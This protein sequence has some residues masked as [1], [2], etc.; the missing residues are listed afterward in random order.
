MPKLSKRTSKRFDEPS[1][2]N[3][4]EQIEINRRK[5]RP[6]I[7]KRVMPRESIITRKIYTCELYSRSQHLSILSDCESSTKNP[8]FIQMSAA[9]VST[10]DW[11]TTFFNNNNNRCHFVLFFFL[12]YNIFFESELFNKGFF[13]SFLFD[14]TR[15]KIDGDD[16]KMKEKKKKVCLFNNIL[17]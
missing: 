12:R 6:T 5:P 1:T 8:A 17:G 2:F 9:F 10:I 14:K 15:E 4:D 11:P 3:V 16:M 13:L 7:A